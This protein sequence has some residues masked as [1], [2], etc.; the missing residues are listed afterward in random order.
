MSLSFFKQ[1]FL[2]G[3]C[4]L[5]I[6][7][8]TKLSCLTKLVIS[9]MLDPICNSVVYPNGLLTPYRELKICWHTD[10]FFKML[11]LE[12]FINNRGDPVTMKIKV[13]LTF[14]ELRLTG[15]YNLKGRIFA[16]PLQ[17]TGPFWSIISKLF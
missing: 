9:K 5:P 4:N 16:L 1:G 11:K 15:Q 10:F 8:T 2:N 12:I 7:G 14:P 17:G 6:R 3:D 13:R